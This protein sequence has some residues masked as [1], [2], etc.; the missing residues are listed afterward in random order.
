MLTQKRKKWI[1]LILA[2]SLL[3][4]IPD[5]FALRAYA[6]DEPDDWEIGESTV[7]EPPPSEDYW[8]PVQSIEPDEAAG[9]QDTTVQETPEETEPVQITP[10]QS[11]PPEGVGDSLLH[12]AEMP[13]YYQNDYGHVMYG[14]G[15]VANNG[16]SA[17]A[18]AMVASYMTGYDYT[19]EMLARYFGGRAEN[20]VARLEIGNDKLKLTHYKARNWH[21]VYEA[22]KQGHV[23][24]IL[25]AAPTPF[26]SNQHF[27][28]LNGIT[29]EGKVMVM[30]P[31]RDNYLK[32]E[33]QQGFESGFD[34]YDIWTCYEGGWIY[35][36]SAMPKHP[37]Y[38]EEPI[39]DKSE[40][41]YP[42]ITLSKED[43]DLIARVVWA[44][45]RGESEKGQ[46]T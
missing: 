41:R 43:L 29:K 32:W 24:I 13:M 38:Y 25:V 39:V 5:A 4:G 10:E 21:Y 46:Q 20:N 37:I 1:S 40:P 17:T 3:L 35:E 6:L 18:L 26:T 22:L 42:N 7:I 12:Y 28:V 9:R 36:K 34:P 45:S 15:T 19:P 16:C 31:N 8:E 2:L 44:E 30:D 33:L 23:A 14:S 11:A 27:L